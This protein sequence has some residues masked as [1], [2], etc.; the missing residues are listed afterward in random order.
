[1]GSQ[2]VGHDWVTEHIAYTHTLEATAWSFENPEND[3][4]IIL[5]SLIRIS[6]PALKK[7]LLNNSGGLTTFSDNNGKGSVWSSEGAGYSWQVSHVLF[8]SSRAQKSEMDLTGLKYQGVSRAMFL[9]E[10]LGDNVS[11]PFP[12]SGSLLH[13]L[14]SGSLYH[15]QSQHLQVF[16]WLWISLPIST[17]MDPVILFGSPG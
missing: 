8:Y 14:A 2:R 16:L 5:W 15:F 1:M 7:R 9:L 6:L 10:A 17:S 12:A 4:W 11:L 3:G 13:S